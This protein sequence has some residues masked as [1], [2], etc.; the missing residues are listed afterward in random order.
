MI[1]IK[2]ENENRA[3]LHI[4]KGTPHTTM[5]LGI[6]MLIEALINE[7]SAN[8]DIDYVLEELKRIYLRDNGGNDE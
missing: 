5:L 3:S 7:S 6:E 4:K 2:T 8:F 1:T